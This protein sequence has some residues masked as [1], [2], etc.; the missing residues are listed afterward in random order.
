MAQ[1]TGQMDRSSAREAFLARDIARKEEVTTGELDV[2]LRELGVDLEPEEHQEMVSAL[3]P[4]M[5]GTVSLVPFL[6]WVSGPGGEEK[7]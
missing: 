1:A 7:R 5:T 4:E 6:D 3:D 2:V